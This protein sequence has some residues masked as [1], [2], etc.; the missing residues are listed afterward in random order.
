M[1]DI[2]IIG[3][4]GAGLSSALSS[5][6]AG[7]SVLVVGK[8]YPTNS[9]T[10]MAQG[11]INA[12][13]SNIGEDSIESHIADTIKSAHGLCDEQ[14]V[15]DLCTNAP[16]TIAWLESIGVP[17]SRLPE[18][19]QGIDSISQRRLGGA[20]ASRACYAQDYTGL[21]ILHTLYDKCLK[22]GIEFRDNYY[23]LNLIVEDG[24]AG[25]AIFLDIYSG[26][27]VQIDA[28]SVIIATGGYASIYHG[29]TT[30]AFG[31]TGDGI[32]CVLRAGGGVS[33]MEFIQFH[34][35]ALK[36]SAILVSESARGEGGLLVNSNG[37]RFVDELK[38]RD[39]VARAIFEQINSGRD[40]FLDIRAL[41]EERLQE[42]LP[43]EVA[44]CKLH[45]NIDPAKELIPIKPVAH[46]TMGGIAVDYTLEVNGINGCFGVGE[47]AN[48]KIHGANRLGGNSLL[49]IVSLGR[50]AGENAYKY[51]IYASNKVSSS[52]QLQ[53]DREYIQSIY[54]NTPSKSF[55]KS[56][57]ELGEIFYSSVGIIRD[58]DSLHNALKSVVDMQVDLSQMGIEDKNREDNSNL[59]EFLEFSSSLLLAPT[60]ISSAIARDESRGA[61]YKEGFEREDDINFKKHIVINWRD[62]V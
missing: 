44:L 11:G 39:E 41:G 34:P 61:H 13:L 31:S 32:A 57:E 9:Q 47:C 40:V 49:E 46:Y 37:E 24:V 38:P 1:V 42:L 59:V 22:E 25:G 21:K 23:L 50:L 35:T 8:S 18:S 28:K 53:K 12:S 48:A 45:E 4:G 17:F 29:Y 43:Q 36:N 51:A 6:Q 20:S 15:R 26:E 16:E 60:I 54:D 30:N 52:N 56:R 2:L 5:K 14:S 27:V 58:N 62:E 33:D 10:S 55:Y 7:A 3:S 19:H